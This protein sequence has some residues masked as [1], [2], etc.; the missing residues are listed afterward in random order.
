VSKITP[1]QIFP[2]WEMPSDP[3][4][5]VWW[6]MHWLLKV[7]VRFFWLPIIAM[8]TYEIIAN[9]HVGSIGDALIYGFVTLAIGFGIWVVLYVVLRLVNLWVKI[10]QA[11]S[12]ANR[13]QQSMFNSTFSYPYTRTDTNGK[14][15]E[16]SIEEIKHEEQ[17][18]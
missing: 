6:F 16:G 5:A 2:R 12:D 10:T 3:V 4:K 17:R 9:A 11:I 7:L 8:V 15:V 18:Q 1:K 14:V 13:A